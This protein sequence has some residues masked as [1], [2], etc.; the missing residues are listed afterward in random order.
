MSP[1]IV[2]Y[3]EPGPGEM[4]YSERAGP[5]GLHMV[6]GQREVTE[7]LYQVWGMETEGCR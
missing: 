7:A 4:R 3:L 5:C 1:L 6:G 2:T